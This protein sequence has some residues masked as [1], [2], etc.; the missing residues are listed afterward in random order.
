MLWPVWIALSCVA[1]LLTWNRDPRASLA[2]LAGLLLG[3]AAHVAVPDPFYLWACAALWVGI[4]GL[5]ITQFD[6][7]LP[8]VL[9]VLSAMCYPLAR[10]MDAPLAIGSPV[11]VVS[12]VLG[13]LALLAAVSGGGS[14]RRV[15]DHRGR[16]LGGP[17]HGR[18]AGVVA[19][20]QGAE[21]EGG[22]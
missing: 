17:R 3:R 10:V 1:V 16:I 15:V 11:F 7:P 9:V 8:G 5:L 12:D 21:T 2:I 19:G 18:R 14:G 4:G 22:R 13:G 6:A 20:M